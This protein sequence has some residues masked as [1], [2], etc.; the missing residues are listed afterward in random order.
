[1]SPNTNN[2]YLWRLADAGKI[3][4]HV[5]RESRFVALG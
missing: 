2:Q 1:M 5:I 3:H 4:T